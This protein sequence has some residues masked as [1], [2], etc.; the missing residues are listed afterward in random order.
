MVADLGAY[1]SKNA[2]LTTSMDKKAINKSICNEPWH[3]KIKW[4]LQQGDL[5]KTCMGNHWEKNLI[6]H[7]SAKKE[8]IES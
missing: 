5:H 1:L 4:M 3:K 6:N 2:H 8:D 7:I